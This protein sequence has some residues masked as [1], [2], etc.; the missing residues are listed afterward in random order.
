MANETAKID[1]NYD[2]SLTGVD[3]TTGEIRKLKTDANG[4]LLVV[5][6]VSVTN[7]N[8]IGDVN[9]GVPGVGDDGKHLQWDNGAGEFNLV[10]GGDVSA[11]AVITD[12]AVVRGD[13]G[14]KGVQ[15]ST[16]T[17]SDAGAV[18]GVASLDIDAG[19]SLTI[20][21][22]S[23][24]SDAAGTA[25]LS[26]IDA[27]DATTEATIEAAIDTLANL[28]SVQ[29]LAVTLA[30]AGAD[31]ILGWDDTAGAYE[32][33]TQAE[34]LAV[35]GSSSLTAQG[36]VELATA[37]ETTTGTDATRAVTPDG[38]AGSDYG[39][40]IVSIALL[41]NSTNTSVGDGA[42]SVTYTVP[43]EIN[44]WNLVNAHASVETAGT[45]NTTDIQ[46]HN[47]TQT[48]DMLSTKITIDSAE[49]TSY[50]AAT[51]PVIDAANDDVATGDKLR[52]D[53]D[54]ISTTPAVGLQVIL[55]FQLP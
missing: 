15:E 31:A 55:T 40:R 20:N 34:V 51:A 10:A 11:A 45:T 44:G 53:V 26:N 32:N 6:D 12:N 46:I 25:T 28:T 30:D 9:V 33:L 8:D 21:T 29:G 14:A 52:F 36:V 16:V 4:R 54:A 35:I 50:T 48:A 7:L 3:E 2:K 42:G 24:I 47:V 49:L 13:G 43:S 5:G 27:L 23:I 41:N 39:K 37:A 18:D 17:I 19:G 1:A 38:L 22:T